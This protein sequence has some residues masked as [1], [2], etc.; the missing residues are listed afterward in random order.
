MHVGVLDE[1]VLVDLR[2]HGHLLA[3]EIVAPVHLSRPGG[4]RG[5]AHG[6]TEAPGKVFSQHVDQSALGCGVRG[7]NNNSKSDTHNKESTSWIVGAKGQGKGV[8]KNTVV[9]LV[10]L[11]FEQES[12][13]NSLCFLLCPPLPSPPLFPLPS[14]LSFSSSVL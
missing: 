3:E 4:A 8:L 13:N 14:F 9:C 11:V 6:E 2:L 12:D 7:I 5:V 1:L 10:L